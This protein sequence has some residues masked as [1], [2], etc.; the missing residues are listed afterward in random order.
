MKRSVDRIELKRL[1]VECIIGV[2]PR[3]R[4]QSQPLVVHLTL[5]TDTREAGRG[6]GLSSTIDYSQLA[7]EVKFLL[8]ACRFELI[9]EAAEAIAAWLLSP[10]KVRKG[11]S[12]INLVEVAI[13]KPAAMGGNALPTITVRREP[14]DFDYECEDSGFGN[15]DIIYEIDAVGVYE[16]R[17]AP[18]SAIPPHFHREMTEAELIL[19]QGLECQDEILSAGLAH[20]WPKKLVHT[21]KNTTDIEASI[22]C[23]D[24]P[25]FMREEEVETNSSLGDRHD[26]Q[27]TRYFGEETLA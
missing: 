22:L 13:E 27:P 2:Y 12:R 6:G 17:I 10:G 15:V 23:V 26:A 19:D 24:R 20:F 9:E 7:G 5:Q 21:Y 8:E 4:V 18:G 25:K 3:E 16:L 14:S 1:E 11:Q